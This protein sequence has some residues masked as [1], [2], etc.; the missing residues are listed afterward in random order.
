MLNLSRT[1]PAFAVLAAALAAGTATAGPSAVGAASVSCGT[2][3]TIGYVGPTTGPV[4]SIGEE[5]RQWPPLLRLEVERLAQ[6][7]DQGRRG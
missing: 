1:V 7:A 5:L 6:A 3:A 4:A 2:S